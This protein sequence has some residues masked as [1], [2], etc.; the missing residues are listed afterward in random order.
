MD[1]KAEQVEFKALVD[2]LER[3]GA[4]RKKRPMTTI[5][6]VNPIKKWGLML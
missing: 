4:K 2:E 6:Y 5:Y 1:N 3:L